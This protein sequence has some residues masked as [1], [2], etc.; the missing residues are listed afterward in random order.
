V[1]KYPDQYVV[2]DIETTGLNVGD[3]EIIE[4]A[5]IEYGPGGT[6]ND[7][8]HTLVCPQKKPPKHILELTGIQS[9]ELKDAPVFKDIL[10]EVIGWLGCINKDCPLVTYNG[11]K[12][13]IPILMLHIHE[14]WPEYPASITP[15]GAH[16]HDALKVARQRLPGLASYSLT[17]VYE[18]LTGLGI[19]A[20]AHRARQDCICLALIWEMI[21]N[22]DPNDALRKALAKTDKDPIVHK[23][24]L[25]LQPHHL[26]I[27]RWTE[28]ASTMPC[29]NEEDFQRTVNAHIELKRL[30]TRL[31]T[32]RRETLKPIKDTAKQ[33]ESYY[34]E[35]A[36]KPITL[37]LEKIEENQQAFLAART[38]EREAVK[39]AQLEQ[40]EKLADAEREKKLAEGA[41][42]ADA[43]EH[44][45]AVYD[46]IET[47]ISKSQAIKTD[48]DRGRAT[49]TTDWA[50]EIVNPNQVDK[51]L[52]SPDLEKIR[53]AVR[54][55]EGKVPIPGVTIT[56]IYKMRSRAKRS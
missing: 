52:W 36:T 27:R 43:N 47:E 25:S 26:K 18:H 37:A 14:V 33:V 49:V 8:W 24:L 31:T 5:F 35:L 44:A 34:R 23:A 12:F 40:A 2:L 56:P 22:L 20:T 48:T 9:A 41:P 55:T 51:R 46:I 11:T 32:L 10:D 42:A 45:E 6:Q 4:I 15:G 19:P 50:C 13:D 39:E 17:N 53:A 28:S 30:K 16:H 54:A 7:E 1:V 3:A 38:R 29:D 21:K